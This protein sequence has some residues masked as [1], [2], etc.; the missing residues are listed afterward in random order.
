MRRLIALTSVVAVVLL[1]LVLAGRP[2]P[3]TV[4]Q[5]ASPA[6]GP[7]GVAAALLG[8]GQPAVAPGHELTLRRITIAPGGGIPAHTHPGA[9]VIYL[10]SG[11]W[12]YT[13]LGGTVRLTRAAVAGTPSPAEDLAVGTEAILHA[14]DVLYVEEPG[15]AI[16]NA[17]DEPVVL[18][19]GGLTRVGDPFTT[20]TTGMAMGGTQA[21]TPA[22]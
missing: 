17:G 19:I 21:A 9:L 22:P 1:G 20:A 7:V 10:E 18:L 3:Q 14:G 16:R 5:E 4:A 11:T 6:A 8:G 12:G 15:D 13:P 2:A